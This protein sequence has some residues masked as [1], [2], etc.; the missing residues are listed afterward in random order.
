MFCKCVTAVA[1]HKSEL[2]TK[3]LQYLL[4][5]LIFQALVLTPVCMRLHPEGTTGPFLQPSGYLRLHQ[6]LISDLHLTLAIQ[7]VYHEI[8]VQIKLKKRQQQDVLPCKKVHRFLPELDLGKT[9]T[10]SL[11]I[12]LHCIGLS[13]SSPWTPSKSHH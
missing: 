8:L 1:V 13:S 10:F 2:I 6:S 5:Y 3:F 11:S 12:A 4:I 9:Y 7:P